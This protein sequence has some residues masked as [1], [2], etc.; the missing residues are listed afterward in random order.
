MLFPNAPHSEKPEGA[1]R[2]AL[3]TIARNRGCRLYL[4]SKRPQRL[5]VDAR[6]NA[7]H[8]A[9]FRSDSEKFLEGCANFGDP[10]M[11]AAAHSLPRGEYLYRGPF[12]ADS[13]PRR[14][15]AVTSPL[16]FDSLLNSLGGD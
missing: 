16:P 11:F 9:V 10:R 8:V 14:H 3:L 13:R 5:H 6:E 4:A 15:N 2:A 1:A 7:A 12:D